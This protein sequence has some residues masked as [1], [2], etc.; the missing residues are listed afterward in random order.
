MKNLR[1]NL[2]A[3]KAPTI[4]SAIGKPDAI[5]LKASV[6]IVPIAVPKAVTNAAIF[7]SPFLSI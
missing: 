3:M 1:P 6:F 5:K 2:I 4:S 7:N